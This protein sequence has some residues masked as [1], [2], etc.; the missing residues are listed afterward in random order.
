MNKNT[1]IQDWME[2]KISP[3]Q[4]EELKADP[5][6]SESIAELEQIL[7]RSS[8]LTPP[9]KKSTKQAWDEIADTLDERSPKKNTRVVKFNP[10]VK[11]A[12]AATVTLVFLVY[13][14][15]PSSTTYNTLAGEQLTYD[16]P[17]G[18]KVV[19]NAETSISFD[20]SKWSEERVIQLDGEAYFDVKSGM[21]FRVETQIGN[22][23]VL[24]TTFNAYNRNGVLRVSC[25]EG[26][27]KVRSSSEERVLT[28]GQASKV[29]GEV[30]ENPKR[31]DLE[32]TA[33]WRTGE[34]YYENA[35]FGEVID[36]LERQ[37][38]IKVDIELRDR[39][40]TGYFNNKNLDEALKLVLLPM[41][42]EYEK[43][44]STIKVK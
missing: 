3:E 30:V 36:E 17:D 44:G 16:L 8:E 6:Y 35:P 12:I 39:Y 15:L 14:L 42:L 28:E 43:D 11:L 1:F 33:T 26:K 25:F 9:R 22:I 32:K 23:E 5:A 24:G 10:L 13:F 20:A 7:S 27:V 29:V 4:L 19:L 37:Y 2:G 18:T 41:S 38:Q 21:P 34:F 40:Y 31:F